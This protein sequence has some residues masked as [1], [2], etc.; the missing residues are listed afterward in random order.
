[1]KTRTIRSRL[2]NKLLTLNTLV[3]AEDSGFT[4]KLSTQDLI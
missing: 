3:K 2:L 1:M 4:T